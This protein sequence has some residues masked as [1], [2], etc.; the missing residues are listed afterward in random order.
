MRTVDAVLFDKTGTLTKGA[1]AVTGVAA[2]PGGS[3]GRGAAAGRPRSR[4]TASTPWRGRSSPP[5]ATRGEPAAAGDFRSLTGRGVEATV[6]GATLAV[7]G[8]AL[9]RELP[10]RCPSDLRRLA[11]GTGRGAAVLHL[12]R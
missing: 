6:D 5:A 7:G 12:V 10:R 4:P 11:P 3:R 9:L 2:A 8:P 1:H